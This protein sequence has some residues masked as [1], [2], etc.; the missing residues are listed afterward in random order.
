MIDKELIEKLYLQHSQR[1][2]RASFYIVR[3][4]HLA[5]EI[6]HDTFVKAAMNLNTIQDL[7][8]IEGWLCRIAANE[9]YSVLRKLKKTQTLLYSDLLNQNT[10]NDP[11]ISFTEQETHDEVRRALNKLEPDDLLLVTLYYYEEI[12][13]KDI[14]DILD[15]PIGTVKSRMFRIK[16][17][18]QSSLRGEI[19]G[20]TLRQIYP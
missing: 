6:V 8:K 3:D 1:V 12:T 15:I 5:E 7:N 17:K 2:Y 19:R 4:P 9:T 16:R 14:S 11:A 13:F 18:I 10:E 20:K